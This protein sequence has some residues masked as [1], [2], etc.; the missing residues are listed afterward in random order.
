MRGGHTGSRF[1][2]RTSAA[3]LNIS[4]GNIVAKQY[5]YR[6]EQAQAMSSSKNAEMYSK[7]AFGN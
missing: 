6:Q 3:A 5:Q 1:Q 2:Y 4:S 7:M